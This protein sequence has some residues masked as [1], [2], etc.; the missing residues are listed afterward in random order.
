MD[1]QAKLDLLS[2][3]KDL[4]D[5]LL[6]AKIEPAKNQNSC[7]ISPQ[8]G[9]K[10]PKVPQG[11]WV[12]I[13]QNKKPHYILRD[14]SVKQINKFLNNLRNQLKS[15]IEEVQSQ[16]KKANRVPPALTVINNNSLAVTRLNQRRLTLESLSVSKKAS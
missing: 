6:S 16:I 13:Q 10:I 2:K 7:F 4:Q 8:A 3:D 1:K 9:S 15:E 14:F 12:F 5:F 11:F